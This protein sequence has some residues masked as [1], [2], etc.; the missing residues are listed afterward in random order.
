MVMPVSADTAW[1][2]VTQAKKRGE[3]SSYVREV[4]GYAVKSFK[5]VVEAPYPMTSILAVL[6]D[7]NGLPN[8]TSV[9]KSISRR[10]LARCGVLHGVSYAMACE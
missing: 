5:G 10:Q 8:C 9:R 2:T 6:S 1:Q 3:V 4:A 7:I